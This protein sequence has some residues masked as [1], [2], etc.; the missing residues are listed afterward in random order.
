MAGETSPPT[1]AFRSNHP[2]PEHNISGDRRLS[3]TQEQ[4]HEVVNIMKA[5]V[6]KVV[7]VDI[8]ELEYSSAA[9]EWRRKYW[10][11]NC[12]MLVVVVLIC[13]VVLI[14]ICIYYLTS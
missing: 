7:E 13:A 9:E 2:E 12:K 10:R 5:N 6:D 3:V 8:S 11:K 14:I 1:V 4:L